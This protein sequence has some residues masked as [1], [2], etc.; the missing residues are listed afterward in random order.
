MECI[1][2][3]NACS[4]IVAALHNNHNLPT[5]NGREPVLLTMRRSAIIVAGVTSLLVAYTGCRNEADTGVVFG[6][7]TVR[8]G[9]TTIDVLIALTGPQMEQGLKYRHSLGEDRGMLFI[10]SQPVRTPFWMKDTHIPLSIAFINRE[11]IIISIKE[12]A[13][14]NDQRMYS[15]PGPFLYALEMNQGWFT[16]NN[17]KVGDKIIIE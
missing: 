11:G 5:Q 10:Y 2:R 7:G 6:E 12:M 13:P 15:P 9:N 4:D 8:I 17:V 1:D 3:V 14:D 16:E